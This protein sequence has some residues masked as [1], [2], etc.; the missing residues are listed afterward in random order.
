MIQVYPNPFN[1]NPSFLG[2]TSIRNSPDSAYYHI[3]STAYEVSIWNESASQY[4]AAFVYRCGDPEAWAPFD[5]PWTAY[6]YGVTGAAANQFTPWMNRTSALFHHLN[7]GTDSVS[8]IKVG[9]KK[10]DITSV[11]IGPYVKNFNSKWTALDSSSI[12]ITGI[13]VYDKLVI[14]I[15]RDLSTP[16]Y[17]FANPIDT[18]PPAQDLGN[19]A[20]YFYVSAGIW[21]LSAITTALGAVYYDGPEYTWRLNVPSNYIVYLAPG[22][23]VDGTFSVRGKHNVTFSGPG[24]IDAGVPYYDNWWTTVGFDAVPAVDDAGKL[25]RCPIYS[26]SGFSEPASYVDPSGIKVIGPTIVNSIAY[27]GSCNFKLIDNTKLICLWPNTDGFHIKDHWS[28][29]DPNKYSSMTR[30]FLQTGDDSTY[31]GGNQGGGDCLISS[32]YFITQA[33]TTFRTYFGDYNYN[34]FRNVNDYWYSAIDIDCRSYA[35]P[36]YNYISVPLFGTFTNSIF[37]ISPTDRKRYWKAYDPNFSSIAVTNHL[38]SGIRVDNLLDVPLFDLGPRP[39]P[40]YD[41][42]PFFGELSGII[43]KDITASSHP[44]S[45]YNW[46]RENKIFGRDS[47]YKVHDVS[48]INVTIDGEPLTNVNKDDSIV[49]YNK[50]MPRDNDPSL[51]SWAGSSVADV[52]IIIGDSIAAG[53][54]SKF[55]QRVG[56]NYSE[57]PTELTGCYIYAPS[58]NNFEIIRPGVNVHAGNYY[59]GWYTTGVAALES[60]LAWKMRQNSGD[61][62]V[63]IIKY[64]DGGTMPVSGT[65][66]TYES[67]SDPLQAANFDRLDWSVSSSNEMFRG[68]SG[69]VTSAFHE[70]STSYKHVDLKSVIIFLGTNTPIQTAERLYNRTSVTA[71]LGVT[72]V[73]PYKDLALVSS[74]IN[75]EISS[76][77]S[78]IGGLLGTNTLDVDLSYTNYIWT[79]PLYEDEGFYVELLNNY[80]KEFNNKVRSFSGI[81]ERLYQSSALSSTL[82]PLRITPYNPP[83]EAYYRPP[84]DGVHYNFSGYAKITDDIYEILQ[85]QTS[86]T[87]DPDLN[88][89]INITFRVSETATTPYIKVDGTWKQADPYIKVNGQWKFADPGVKISGDWKQ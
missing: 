77:I 38:F 47:K 31:V 57:M 44:N 5:G 3:S 36:G 34:D 74:L 18:A 71:T 87:T 80:L 10:G 6:G 60:T 83:T 26:F 21:E 89:N 52:Y 82:V 70:L 63:Y 51:P 66:A 79:L 73:N 72:A 49:W 35:V 41:Y 62:D 9:Y 42:S 25:K 55:S 78:G 14:H 24:V 12:E 7:Y 75:T 40:Y 37:G 84:D 46:A 11:D 19:S 65:S 59:G 32:C 27:A 76:L 20:S 81:E 53:Y 45:K 61:R 58:S 2:L 29:P 8:K 48:F 16:L 39:Y 22:S 33:G 69:L 23:Y 64:A 15:N 68:F 43:F 54:D 86:S 85:Q 30:S 88:P 17:V 28:V 4:S 56:T 67:Q 1:Y 13:N 50:P